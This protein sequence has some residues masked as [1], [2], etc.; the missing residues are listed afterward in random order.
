MLEQNEILCFLVV[1]NV[2]ILYLFKRNYV[3]H[4]LFMLG[5]PIFALSCEIVAWFQIL[6]VLFSVLINAMSIFY[7]N[8][9]FRGKMK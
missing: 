5:I 2:V 7:I 9:E 6:M 4:L 8:Q 3:L 1:L